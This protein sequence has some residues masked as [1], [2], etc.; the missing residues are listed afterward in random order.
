MYWPTLVYL[1]S[2]ISYL[3]IVRKGGDYMWS[4]KIIKNYYTTEDELNEYGSDGWELVTVSYHRLYFKKWV[5]PE[6]I[7]SVSLVSSTTVETELFHPS[8]TG[9]TGT[10]GVMP[11]EWH[12]GT[13]HGNVATG[14]TGPFIS[15]MSE[16][17]HNEPIVIQLPDDVV[18]NNHPPEVV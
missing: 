18:V 15:P 5:E 9:P 8:Y 16:E 4:Y 1:K 2:F 17:V 6:M 13:Y 14:T 12:T 3:N 7:L 11:G 10:T